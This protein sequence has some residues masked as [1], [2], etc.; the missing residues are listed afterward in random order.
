MAVMDIGHVSMFM[1]G[2]RVQ[3]LV[4]MSHICCIMFVKFVMA[5]A[6]LVHNRHM[7]IEMGMLF[8]RQ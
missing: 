1:L 3:M 5:M 4:G 8:V 7:D 2:V 6:M